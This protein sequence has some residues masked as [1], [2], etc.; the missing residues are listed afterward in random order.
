MEKQTYANI[1]WEDRFNNKKRETTYMSD[2]EDGRVYTVGPLGTV[3]ISPADLPSLIRQVEFWNETLRKR[4]RE[5]KAAHRRAHRGLPIEDFRPGW[6]EWYFELARVAATRST[7]SR[8]A[9]GAVL[10]QDDG[11][12]PI[13][14]GYNGATRSEKHCSEEDHT[15][16]NGSCTRAVHAERNVL[17]NLLRSPFQAVTEPTTGKGLSLYVTHAPCFDCA[18]FLAASLPKLEAVVYKEE[19]G[20][21]AGLKGLESWT[22]VYK[23][24]GQI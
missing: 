14:F 23:Y 22:N 18:Q 7:C 3:T 21:D 16:R 11:R 10:V 20:S 19:Y 6:H 15:G 17:Y 5:Y 9:V 4:F 13:A 1:K 8:L 2:T 24:K 12:L